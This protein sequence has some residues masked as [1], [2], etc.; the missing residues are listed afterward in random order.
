[1]PIEC[2]ASDAGPGEESFTSLAGFGTWGR[3]RIPGVHWE[4]LRY[5]GMFA[6]R[7]FALLG[8]SLSQSPLLSQTHIET[9]ATGVSRLGRDCLLVQ[10]E[11]SNSVI[12]ISHGF[13]NVTRLDATPK[14][15]MLG[16]LGQYV[17]VRGFL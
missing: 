12:S 7:G 11:A 1:M 8:H 5:I 13:N 9:P 4:S 10:H 2:S 17:H 3:C 14:R 15:L 16:Y 6:T